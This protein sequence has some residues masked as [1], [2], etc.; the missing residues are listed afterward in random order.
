MALFDQTGTARA[1]WPA[2]KAT[3]DGRDDPTRLW[4]AAG[5][6]LPDDLDGVAVIAL[7]FPKF[8][9]GRAF[10]QARQLRARGYRG[11]LWAVGEVLIDQLALMAR[12][13]FDGFELPDDTDPA[14]VAAKTASFSAAYQTNPA[15]PAPAWLLRRRAADTRRVS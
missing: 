4:V 3:L 13:G 1:D 10:S 2:E 12:A 15:G 8:A 14:V 11:A 5:E 9:D 6:A 7:E